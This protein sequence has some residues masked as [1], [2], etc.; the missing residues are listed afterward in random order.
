MQVVVL[1]QNIPNPFSESTVINYFIPDNINYA[2]MIFS[3]NY[4]KILKTVDITKSGSGAIKVYAANLSS[5][6]YTYALMV[7]G[8][9]VDSK[10]MVCTKK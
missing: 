1:E 3:D 4:G 2:Q 8:K 7:D 6:L 9:V 10:K 5:G